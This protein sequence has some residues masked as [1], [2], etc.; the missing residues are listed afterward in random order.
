[1]FHLDR[2]RKAPEDPLL[3]QSQEQPPAEDVNGE[4]E[5]E[6]DHVKASRI[7]Y[8]KLQYKAQWVG[9]DP[10][11]EW[12][13]ASDFRNTPATLARYHEEYPDAPGPPKNLQN[14]LNAARNDL[15]A[16]E[17]NDNDI[18]AKAGVTARLR[19]RARFWRIP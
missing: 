13:K 10:D 9:F 7:H 5:W 8:G 14:W 2:L 6:I 15:P 19:Q 18:P 12:Y 3:G 4:P 16:P 1:M 17:A 11:D